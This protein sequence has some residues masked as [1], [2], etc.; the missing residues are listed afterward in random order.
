MAI[1]ELRSCM[2]KVETVLEVVLKGHPSLV[3]ILGPA[4]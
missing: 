3:E 2:K 1:S 4:S